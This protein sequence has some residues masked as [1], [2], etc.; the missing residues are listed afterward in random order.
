MELNIKDYKLTKTKKYFKINHIFFMIDGINRKALD[1]LVAQ[2][3]LK[4]VEFNFYKV[5]NSTTI[6]FLKKSIY[7][8]LN[9][10]IKS[11]TFLIKPTKPQ[12]FLKRTVIN[13]L[14]PLLCE[15]LVIKL[16]NRLYLKDSLKNT[17]SLKYKET[18]LLLYQ[19]QLTNL[20]IY[21][22]FSK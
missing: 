21:S 7:Y 15:L 13:I 3:T 10:T 5:F 12:Y 14:N 17:Y 18:K 11:S 20:K 6:K 19:F 8:T 2:Q 4:T 22:K 1:W 9:S 16:N